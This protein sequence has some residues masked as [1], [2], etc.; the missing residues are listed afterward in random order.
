ME[1]ERHFFIET[2]SEHILLRILRRIRE[3]NRSDIKNKLFGF[4]A[5][6]L[7]VL[8]V[9]KDE[10]GDSQVSQLRVAENGEFIDRWPHGFFTE[11]D[12]DLFDE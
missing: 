2:H 11:R 10:K 7:C 9:D 12:A 3:T 4:T 5:D 8:Y 1:P 6:Q